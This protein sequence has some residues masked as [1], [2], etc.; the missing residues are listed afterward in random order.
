V[1]K[2]DIYII[3]NNINKKVYIGQA[4]NTKERF[5]SHCKPSSATLNNE[6][7]GKAINKYGREHFWYEILENQVENYDELEKSYIKKYNSIVPYGYNLMKGGEKP[8]LL[9]GMEHPEAILSEQDIINLTN[10]LRSTDESFVKLANKYGFSSNVS[11]CEFNSGVTYVRDIEYPI[12]KNPTNGILSEDDV[13]AIISLLKYTYRSYE[14]IATQ[15]GVEYKAV[16][17]INKGIFHKKDN[18][19]YP[20]R[21]SKPKSNVPKLTYEQVTDIISLIVNTELSLREIGRRFNVGYEDILNI[22]N[23]TTKL[24]RRKELDYPLRPNN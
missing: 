23:G 14:D 24:Y 9:R 12:R 2:K 19:E 5:Q 15:F 22:K 10:D 3:K 7:I 1:L 20:I 18:E 6:V 4:I 16:A 13:D 17:R 21:I 8:P 11:I